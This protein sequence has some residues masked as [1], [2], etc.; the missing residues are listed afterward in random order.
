[1]GEAKWRTRKLDATILRDL[2]E[3]KLPALEAAGFTLDRDLEVLLFARAG[4][5]ASLRAAAA[6]DERVTLVDVAAALAH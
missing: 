5:S 1:M 4:Y 2:Y 6:R 3:Y